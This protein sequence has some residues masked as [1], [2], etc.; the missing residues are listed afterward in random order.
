MN[1]F[2][3]AP[4]KTLRGLWSTLRPIPGGRAVF[5]RLVG[6]AAPYTGSIGAHVDELGPGHAKVVLRDRRRVR[7]HLDCVHAVALVNLA[8]MA[9]GLAMSMG[10]P[11]DARGILS[12][13]SIEYLKKA[14]GRL[15]AECRCEV[16][17]TNE[18][19]EMM[20]EGNIHNDAGELVARATAR[21]LIGPSR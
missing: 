4:G 10:M 13:I 19:R 9:T 18:R 8:E 14:R 1:P 21:W 5:S 6:T 2:S 17:A 12:G 16:P 15:T 20:V 11:D 3:N 7:N